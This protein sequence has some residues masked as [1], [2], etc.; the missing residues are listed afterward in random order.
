MEMY[1]TIVYVIADEILSVFKVK[2]EGI[3]LYAKRGSKAK[4]RLRSFE[5]EKQISSKRQIIETA[6]SSILNLFPRHIRCRTEKGFL[7]KVFGFVIAYCIS[8]F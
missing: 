4:N 1:A 6:F 5:E 8:F 7:I 2:D 3:H